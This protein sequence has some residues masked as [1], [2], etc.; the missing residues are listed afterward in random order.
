L[1]KRQGW[2]V[3]KI[4][5][6]GI[7]RE[8]QMIKIFLIYIKLWYILV[9]KYALGELLICKKIPVSRSE[10]ILKNSLLSK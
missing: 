6:G 4:G 7:E 1:L 5:D 2:N 8:D 10:N 9:H 3:E